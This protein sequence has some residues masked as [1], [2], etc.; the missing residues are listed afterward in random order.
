MRNFIE[1]SKLLCNNNFVLWF[2]RNNF[3]EGINVVNDFS[4][5]EIID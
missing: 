2:L 4:I 5:S 3:P 1:Y